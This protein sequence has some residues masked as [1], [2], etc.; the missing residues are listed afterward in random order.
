MWDMTHSYVGHASFIYG[1]RPIHIWDMTQTHCLEQS[2]SS[3]SYVG[4]DLFICGTCLVHIW[5]MTHSY[6]GHDSDTLP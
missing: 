4:H 6:M 3:Y 5:D 1:T 2:V